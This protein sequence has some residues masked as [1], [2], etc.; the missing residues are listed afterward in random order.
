MFLNVTNIE[1]R[2]VKV[3]STRKWKTADKVV[4]TAMFNIQRCLGLVSMTTDYVHVVTILLVA[5][6]V[7]LGL[8]FLPLLLPPTLLSFPSLRY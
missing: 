1:P 3:R 6:A 5:T 8:V 7:K 4:F 2:S